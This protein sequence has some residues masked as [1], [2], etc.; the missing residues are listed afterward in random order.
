M[1]SVHNPPACPN[2][3]CGHAEHEVNVQKNQHLGYTCTTA[4]CPC[5]P[6]LCPEDGAVLVGIQWV[7]GHFPTYHHADGKA[8]EGTP[9]LLA[10]KLIVTKLDEDGTPVGDPVP[11][12]ANVEVRILPNPDQKWPPIRVVDERRH[13]TG[14]EITP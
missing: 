5:K 10:T 6:R 4:G 13:I 3:L 1:V 8:H 14:M 12:D 9:P 11:F 7:I 2:G